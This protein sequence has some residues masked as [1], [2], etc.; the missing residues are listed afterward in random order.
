MR[1][2]IGN[3]AKTYRVLFYFLNEILI[4][5]LFYLSDIG[6]ELT[7][8]VHVRVNQNGYELTKVGT[9]WLGPYELT[10]NRHELTKQ[11]TS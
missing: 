4:Q 9:S 3:T 8:Q 6:Y 11:S 5:D 7:K 10:K 1:Q 2:K